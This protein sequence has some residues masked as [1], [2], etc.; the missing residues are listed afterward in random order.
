MRDETEPGRGIQELLE[1]TKRAERG[2]GHDVLQRGGAPHVQWRR[3]LPLNGLPTSCRCGVVDQLSL[4][5]SSSTTRFESWCGASAVAAIPVQQPPE[6]R[7]LSLE[8][9]C[10]LS[11]RRLSA[12]VG[13]HLTEV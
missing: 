12:E 6:V 10:D 7:G 3:V 4:G 1:A 13:V 5:S 2:V 9:S 11:L 8:F